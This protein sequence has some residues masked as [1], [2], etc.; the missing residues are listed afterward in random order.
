MGEGSGDGNDTKRGH[1]QHFPDYPLFGLLGFTH[2]LPVE[3]CP[4]DADFPGS[5]A[6]MN[7]RCECMRR[8]IDELYRVKYARREACRLEGEGFGGSG[9]GETA[10]QAGRFIG[11]EVP[12]DCLKHGFAH[13]VTV[14]PAQEPDNPTPVPGKD[15]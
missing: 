13:C 7:V 9:E 6:I 5:G 3:A 2:P 11:V 1:G 12:A 14:L 8:W 4:F 10:F 15:D